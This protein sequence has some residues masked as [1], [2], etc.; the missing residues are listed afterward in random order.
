MPTFFILEYPPNGTSS[1]AWKDGGDLCSAS[2]GLGTGIV[3]QATGT[4]GEP[5]EET[6]AR[7]YDQTMPSDVKGHVA[8]RRPLEPGGFHPR[9]WRDEI[10]ALAGDRARMTIDVMGTRPALRSAVNASRLLLRRLGR[11]FEYIEPV[12]AQSG[13]HGHEQR[14]LLALA[15]MEVETAWKGV[16]VANK[17]PAERCTTED[18]VKLLGPMR[19]ADW[20]VRLVRSEA[21]WIFSPFRTWDAKRASKS[22]PWYQA[23]NETKHNRETRL[24]RATL[25]HV[26]DAF[27]AN[28]IMLAAQFGEEEI[29]RQGLDEF[30]VETRPTWSLVEQYVQDVTD[31]DPNARRWHARHLF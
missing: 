19:L 31:E 24:D 18:Y 1:I 7:E 16:L 29:G 4:T 14:Q 15:C 6:I 17:Y 11:V 26:L 25:H 28:Y 9:I 30:V 5:T 3:R 12:P 8:H 2:P 22:L 23:Y 27:A 10:H 13:M 20:S 21:N